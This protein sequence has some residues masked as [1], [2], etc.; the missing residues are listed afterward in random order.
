VGNR[1]KRRKENQLR[2]SEQRGLAD[3]GPPPEQPLSHRRLEER[4]VREGWIDGPLRAKIIGRCER[5][6]DRKDSVETNDSGVIF[7]THD[8]EANGAMRVIIAAHIADERLRLDREKLD[9]E[10]EKLAA[11]QYAEARAA[12]D[13]VA[14]TAGSAEPSDPAR[15]DWY[16]TECPCGIELGQCKEHP[17]ARE[18]QRPPPGDW[19]VWAY[20][21]GRGAG[22]TRAGAEWIQQRARSGLMRNGMLIAAIAADIRDI[23]VEGPSGLLSIAPP[24]FRPVYVQGKRRITWPNGAQ[25]VCLTGEEPERARGL[26][27]DTIWADELAAWQRPDMTWDLAM[28]ANR[29]GDQ[30]QAM[31]TTTP[32]RVP[33]LKR[34]IGQ[35]STVMTKDTTYANEAH[36]AKTFMTTIVGMFAGTRLGQQELEAEF[37]E[38]T[39]G[40]WFANFNPQKHVIESAEFHP[41]FPVYLAVDAGTSRYTGAVFFQVRPAD[42]GWAKVTVFGEYLAVDVFSKKNA[43]AIKAVADSLPCRGKVDFVCLDPA[44]D[45]RSSLGPAAY[46]EYE[47]VFGSR[48]TNRWP[49]HLVLDGLDTMEM[50][51]DTDNLLIH[52]RCPKTRESF[53]NYAKAKRGNSFIDKPAD[54][55]PYEDMMDALRGGIRFV[56]PEGREQKSTLRGIHAGRL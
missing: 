34:I 55:H 38:T 3:P 10:R 29:A 13:A 4:A 32:K 20:I 39:E 47:R 36:L 28:L 37:L 6:I 8:R 18:S 22:K 49:H 25:A 30:P 11:K 45:A 23:M 16:G 41:G 54:E 9:L 50:L 43:E 5:T 21:A 53:L 56:M 12:S 35:A 46:G 42:Y 44:A 26:N 52:P 14:G 51:L 2:Q 40:V 1:T 17:R 7:R 15:W 24:D 27:V 31:I 19:T 48:R 33:I